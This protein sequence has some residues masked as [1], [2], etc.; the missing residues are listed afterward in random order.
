VRSTAAHLLAAGPSDWVV[1]AGPDGYSGDEEFFLHF[2]V[3]TIGSALKDH[4]SLDRA[5]FDQWVQTRHSQIEN[6]ELVYI[7]HQLDF[8][9]R[10]G[11]EK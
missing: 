3:Q 6:K 7:A 11:G 1:F 5:Q 8:L 9:G 2:I 4:P 10:V